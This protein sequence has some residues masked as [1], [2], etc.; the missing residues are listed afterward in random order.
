[1]SELRGAWFAMGASIVASLLASLVALPARADKEKV[2]F[3]YVRGAGA[4]TCPD[5]SAIKSSVAARL[6][7]EPFDD[8]APKTIAVAVVRPKGVFQAQIEVRD[9]T[10]AVKGTRRLDSKGS[11]CGELAGAITLAIAIAVDPFGG[12][13]SGA[14]LPL[15]PEEPKDASNATNAAND[16]TADG[17]ASSIGA[18]T[19]TTS[20]DVATS[21]A[22]EDQGPLV[23]A[24]EENRGLRLLA[25]GG[26]VSSYGFEPG[27][28]VGAWV[29][30]AFR[31]PRVSLG[32][33]GRADVP[34]ETTQPLGS[35][36]SG[37]IVGT[38]LPCLHRGIALACAE[39]VLGAIRSTGDGVGGKS[40]SN[41]F[42]A[43]GARLG[44]EVPLGS[45]LVARFAVDGVATLLGA[46][47]EYNGQE[48]WKSHPFAGALSA[49]IA[50]VF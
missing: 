41:P 46:K 1:V 40:Q 48:V 49:G 27:V 36:K 8:E 28:G 32:L 20:S 39:G 9:A 19:T 16:P 5:E 18:T 3:V 6:G 38:I 43:L 26:V 47:L 13:S 24:E 12:G 4:E 31:W 11:D 21:S 45:S 50:G 10:G 34:G 42:V 35:V 25:G 7:Y 30:L 15:P 37:V 22:S 23:D 14:P 17:D 29:G 2:R 44:V 33:E